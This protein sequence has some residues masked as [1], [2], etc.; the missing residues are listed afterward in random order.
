MLCLVAQLC[1]ILCDPMD[2]S[3]PGSSVHGDSP[4][5]NTG[6]GCHAPLQ[7]IFPTQGSN[8]GLLHCRQILYQLNHKGSHEHWG[9]SIQIKVFS[10]YIPRSGIAGSCGNSIFSF[11]RNFHTVH[12]SDYTSLHSHQ[13]KK[14]LFFPCPLQHLLFADLLMMAILTRVR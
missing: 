4:G 2:H 9:A 5:K 10:R 11:L 13:C 8:P 12:H 14:V 7:G 1:P 6:V 3:P